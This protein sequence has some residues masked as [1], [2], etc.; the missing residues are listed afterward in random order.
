MNERIYDAGVIGGGPAGT[1]T[2]IT[3]A[4]AG[5]RVV[6]FEAKT[7]PHDKLCGEFLSPE[8]PA[9]LQKL[10]LFENIAKIGPARIREVRITA[11]SGA[12]H[13]LDLPAEAWGLSRSAFDAALARHAKRLGV[14]IREATRVTQVSGGLQD[15]FEIETRT[16]RGRRTFKCRSVVAAHGKRSSLDRSLQRAFIEQDHPYLAIKRTFQGLSLSR[17]LE[18]HAFPGGY[19]GLSQIERDRQVMCLLVRQAVFRQATRDEH[20]PPIESFLDWLLAQNAQI[21]PWIAKEEHAASGWISI[22]QIPFVRKQRVV[23]DILLVGDAAGL[24]APLVGDGIAMALDGGILA[25]SRL[26][27][28]L[29]GILSP[30]R[31]VEDY[32]AAWQ[33]KFGARLRLSYRLQEVLLR[34]NLSSWAIRLLGILPGLGDSLIRKT[35]G[36]P[37]Q[38]DP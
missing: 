36:L 30:Q 29:Q 8:C 34:A 2:A 16:A 27:A 7:F 18:L 4:A 1:S 20:R 28:Y 33:G 13:Q 37:A 26:L 14:E 15:G 5:A 9:L 3:L 10:G 32:E 17:R 35:R 12:A 24:V 22:S 23:G 19:L 25:G 6:L 31:L 11:P 21:P 38:L